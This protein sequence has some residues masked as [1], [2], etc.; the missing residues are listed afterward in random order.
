MV[1]NTNG[2]IKKEYSLHV[3][4]PMRKFLDECFMK[5]LAD[6]SKERNPAFKTAKI[7]NL[8]PKV[9]TSGYTTAF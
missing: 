5:I 2:V 3:S 4:Y 6:C 9:E 1:L 8:E 7:F